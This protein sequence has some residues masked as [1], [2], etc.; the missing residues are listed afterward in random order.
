MTKITKH[1]KV[2][3]YENQVTQHK[4]YVKK[5]NLSGHP[6]AKVSRLRHLGAL[7]AQP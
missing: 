2:P 4:A 7:R 5:V 3:N 1:P 6:K